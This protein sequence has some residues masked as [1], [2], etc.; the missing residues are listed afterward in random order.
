VW[1]SL[2]FR[3]K[4]NDI[5]SLQAGYTKILGLFHKLEPHG[6]FLNQIRLPKLTDKPLI[7]LSLA[8]ESLGID[9]E[10]Y[11]FKQLPNLGGSN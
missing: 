1:L 8:A 9:S 4:T 3:Q 11:L 5:S 2:N 10:R 6:N 7:A